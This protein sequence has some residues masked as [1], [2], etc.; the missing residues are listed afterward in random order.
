MALFKKTA[1]GKTDRA[2]AQMADAGRCG[3]MCRCHLL[4]SERTGGGQR[5]SRHAAASDLPR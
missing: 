5:V 1:Q 3:V 4:R 2:P